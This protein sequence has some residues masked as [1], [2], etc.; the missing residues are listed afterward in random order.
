M[1]ILRD[2][3]GLALVTL[4]LTG[5]AG[6][7]LGPTGGAI[8]GARSIQINSFQNQTEEPRLI[9]P[10]NTALRKTIQRDG[11]YKLSTHDDA[12]IV[13]NGI[14]TRYTR[15]G[16]TYQPGDIITVRDYN[17]NIF[18]K[19]IATDR[20]TGKI[21]VERE[22]VGKTTIRVGTDLGSAERQAVSMLADDFARNAVSILAD[23]TW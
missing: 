1:R 3:L 12:D 10:L 20:S 2:L 7:K 5:C 14:I 9:E 23:G 22:V 8:A 11:T 15:S 18:A 16:V 17:L 6:Y 19:I 13:L 4:V 21:L